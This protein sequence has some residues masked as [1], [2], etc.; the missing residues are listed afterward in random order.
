MIDLMQQFEKNNQKQIS[1]KKDKEKITYD[2]LKS[3]NINYKKENNDIS[4]KSSI[5]LNRKNKNIKKLSISFVDNKYKHLFKFTSN[6]IFKIIIDDNLN[7]TFEQDFKN[8]I[9][10]NLF[11]IYNNILKYF[12]DINTFNF[13]FMDHYNKLSD[14]I[15][16][17]ICNEGEL[18][19]LEQ[20]INQQK[21]NSLKKETEKIITPISDNYSS[22]IYKELIK[23]IEYKD[24]ILFWENDIENNNV[25]L[26][27]EL[28]EIDNTGR[29]IAI[30]LTNKDS[31]RKRKITK[32][33]LSEL[34]KKQFCF[35]NNIIKDI[36]DISFLKKIIQ[37]EEYRSYFLNIS[38]FYN[39]L[40]PYI[41][42]N[43]F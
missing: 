14:I 23:K 42:A 21:F 37:R 6:V 40:K 35:K 17:L 10:L 9:D 32:S 16:L 18:K 39:F 26:R 13:N 34:L 30:H 24:Y 12:N 38:D 8:K 3:L 33:Q 4:I 31:E 43:S 27:K 36:E 29:N 41:N 28:L 19:N 5:T 7:I 15:H 25:I 1:L 22:S 20:E 2:I 11:K